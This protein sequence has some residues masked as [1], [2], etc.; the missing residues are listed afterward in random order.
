MSAKNSLCK[1][2]QNSEDINRHDFTDINEFPP[3]LKSSCGCKRSDLIACWAISVR[4][5]V[6]T[7]YR[8]FWRNNQDVVFYKEIKMS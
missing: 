3:Y 6:V 7:A 2:I 4:T 1:L 5:A 8:Y